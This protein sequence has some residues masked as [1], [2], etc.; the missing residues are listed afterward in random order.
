[1]SYVRRLCFV[2]FLLFLCL[3]AE[4]QSWQAV[5]PE[6]VGMSAERLERIDQLAQAYIDNDEVG[7]ILTLVVRQGKVVHAEQY[8]WQSREAEIPMDTDTIFRIYSM[9]K[10]ITSVAVLM[11]MEEG[12]LM[13]SDPV[14]RYI[15]AFADVQVFD[16]DAQD[17]TRRVAP[18]RPITIKDLLTH[19]SGLTYGIFG[20]TEVDH[21]YQ[22]ANLLDGTRD[23]EA[24]SNDLAVLPLM[25]HPGKRWQYSVATDV[26]GRIVEVASGQSFASFLQTRIFDPLGMVDTGFHVPAE[27][28]DRFAV[29]YYMDEQGTL[30]IAD[31]GSESQFAKPP[32]FVSGGGGLVSTQADYLRFAQML[33]GGGEIEGVRLLGTKTVELMTMNHLDGEFAPGWGFGLG[34]NVTTNVPRTAMPG[35]PGVFGWSGLAK[36]HFFIDPEEDLIAMVW[37][38]VFPRGAFSLDSQF[39]VAVYQAIID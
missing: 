38:Q 1:M 29:N 8:G 15:P 21:L 9:T 28:L 31:G 30:A 13:L 17:G 11:L 18:R 35:S 7:G 19:T 36:T 37:T 6:T 16:P 4:A 32:R 20:D 26:L 39:K 27:K 33:L 5:P 23:L 34:V 12:Q 25:F 3:P 14:S 24:F 10:P 22:E 2:L